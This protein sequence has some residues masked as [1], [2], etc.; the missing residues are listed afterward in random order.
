MSSIQAMAGIKDAA[1][2]Y[3]VRKL[4]GSATV[5]AQKPNDLRKPNYLKVGFLMVE[6]SVF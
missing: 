3:E 4:N 2:D 5:E 6:S 1:R